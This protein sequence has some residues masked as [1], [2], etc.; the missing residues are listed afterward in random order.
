MKTVIC[1]VC[2]NTEHIALV[3]GND[4]IY[5]FK[6]TILQDQPELKRFDICR[7]CM[8]KIA[9]EIQKA[10]VGVVND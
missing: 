1:D 10:K 4:R 7:S 5:R 2:G 3:T 6:A 9:D 8:C